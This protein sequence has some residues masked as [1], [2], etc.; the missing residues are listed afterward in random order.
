MSRYSRPEVDK[1]AERLKTLEEAV[2]IQLQREECGFKILVSNMERLR[3][4]Y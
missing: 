3:K 4:F 2:M 1:I